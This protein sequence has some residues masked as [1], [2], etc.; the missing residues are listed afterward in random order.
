VFQ[1]YNAKRKETSFT[2]KQVQQWDARYDQLAEFT[3][4]HG[5]CLVPFKD[6]A[7]L[8]LGNWVSKQCRDFVKGIMDPGRKQRLDQLG[9]AWTLEGDSQKVPICVTL[10]PPPVNPLTNAHM[11][12][13][14]QAAMESGY[15]T[16]EQHFRGVD[17]AR[18]N[19]CFR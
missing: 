11:N 19:D 14:R 9:F 2:A 16:A 7:N 4:T 13:T 15:L 8:P 6:D 12:G 17:C 1:Y 5:H 3:H 18:A 10:P